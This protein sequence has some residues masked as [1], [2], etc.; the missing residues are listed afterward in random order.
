MKLDRQKANQFVTCLII[1]RGI[2]SLINNILIKFYFLLVQHIYKPSEDKTVK[3]INTASPKACF[4]VSRYSLIRR[5]T[6]T[7][8]EYVSS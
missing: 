7:H 5:Y 2:V 3:R 8:I 4:V 6:D 1:S